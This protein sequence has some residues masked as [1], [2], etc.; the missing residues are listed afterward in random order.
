MVQ[1]LI[2]LLWLREKLRRIDDQ[3]LR[4]AE[5]E[6]LAMGSTGVKEPLVNVTGIIVVPDYMDILISPIQYPADDQNPRKT[7]H[8]DFHQ[9]T[10]IF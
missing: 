4:N 3:N 2:E 1:L 6:R 8:F 10:I 5:E 9:F 7:T